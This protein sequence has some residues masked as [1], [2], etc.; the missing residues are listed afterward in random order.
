MADQQE[1]YQED[2]RARKLYGALYA[3]IVARAWADDEFREQLLA[4]PA[5]VLS[6]HGFDLAAYIDVKVVSEG[7]APVLEFPLPP[8]PANLDAQTV[9]HILELSKTGV[10]CRLVSK[11]TKMKW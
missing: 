3:K 5:K 9:N 7:S 1:S 2:V 11:G 10:K 6:E 8:R 4:Q